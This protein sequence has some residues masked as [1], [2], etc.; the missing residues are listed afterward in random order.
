MLIG[1]L[2][3]G[4]LVSLFA[5][6]YTPKDEVLIE[7]A[8]LTFNIN[9]ERYQPLFIDKFGGITYMILAK[10]IHNN[11]KDTLKNIDF[12]INKLSGLMNMKIDTVD[13]DSRGNLEIKLSYG[14]KSTGYTVGKVNI[15]LDPTMQ[16]QRFDEKIGRKFLIGGYS[17]VYINKDPGHSTLGI[18][19]RICNFD[20]I[21]E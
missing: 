7:K 5:N 1:L 2:I 11:S 9:D 12:K 3:L 8:T 17:F 4:Y 21:H 16:P 6:Y 18:K 19:G 10:P 13:Y 15:P 14:F 20:C